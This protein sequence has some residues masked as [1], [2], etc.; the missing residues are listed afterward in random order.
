MKSQK[1]FQVLLEPKRQIKKFHHQMELVYK[2]GVL[3]H[4]APWGVLDLGVLAHF[5]IYQIFM[6]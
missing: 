2:L 1:N 6:C 4:F 3:A 5:E